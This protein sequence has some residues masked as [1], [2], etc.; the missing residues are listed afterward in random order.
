V[1][2]AA[3]GSNIHSTIPRK[4]REA[5]TLIKPDRESVFM[6]STTTTA[7]TGGVDTNSGYTETVNQEEGV[8]EDDETTAETENGTVGVLMEYSKYVGSPGVSGILVDC[9][10]GADDSDC[11][12]PTSSDT[13]TNRTNTTNDV[14]G[15][16]YICMLQRGG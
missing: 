16:P 12:L 3:P 2:L 9:Q 13:A 11:I 15:T 6:S 1:N 7:T 10:Y 4:S 14:N 8:N 5:A